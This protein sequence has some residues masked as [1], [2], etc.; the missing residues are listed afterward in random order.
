MNWRAVAVAAAWLGASFATFACSQLAYSGPSPCPAGSSAYQEADVALRLHEVDRNR[1]FRLPLGEV[2]TTGAGYCSVGDALEVLRQQSGVQ[3]FRAVRVGFAQIS[4]VNYCPGEA[5]M[6]GFSVSITVTNGCQAL[7]REDAIRKVVTPRGWPQG[8]TPPPVP[9]PIRARS[10]SASEYNQTFHG[11][12][13][14]Q[15]SATVWAV[16]FPQ[17]TP[18]KLWEVFAVDACTDWV[19]TFSAIDPT[20]VPL[21]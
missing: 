18:D 12:L 13:D 16:W 2:V 6:E 21:D 15:P 1:G 4:R 9:T 20:A 14:L 17:A 10:M 5:C 3:A 8:S 19:S 7:S 11:A